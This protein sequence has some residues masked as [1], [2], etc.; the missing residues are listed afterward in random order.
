MLTAF[1]KSHLNSRVCVK[2]WNHGW[3]IAAGAY[4]SFCRIKRLGVFLLSLDGLLVLCNS[5][6]PIYMYTPGWR[7]VLWELSVS[8]KNMTQDP[9]PGLE[10]TL[11]MRPPVPPIQTR[12][13]IKFLCRRSV[14]VFSQAFLVFLMK[15]SKK[16]RLK[17]PGKLMA[18]SRSQPVNLPSAWP[19][20]NPLITC[21][22]C[23]WHTVKLWE[24]IKHAFSLLK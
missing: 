3:L 23:I 16:R 20:M 12:G 9:Q 11:K 6:V 10:P 5:P 17:Q 7:V 1:A 21:L 2:P 13:F 8:P 22:G 19:L 4:P 18:K 24:L 15:E 14:G